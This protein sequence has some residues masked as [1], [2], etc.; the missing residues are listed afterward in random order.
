MVIDDAFISG[1]R[2]QITAL[3]KLRDSV[4]GAIDRANEKLDL[5]IKNPGKNS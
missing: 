5:L 4:Q 2:N 1:F 3:T